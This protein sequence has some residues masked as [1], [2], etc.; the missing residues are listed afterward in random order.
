MNATSYNEKKGTISIGPGTL[1][2]PAYTA[3]REKNVVFTAG[4]V[5]PVGASGFITGGGISYFWGSH[6]WGW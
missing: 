4:R 2:G 6:G 5:T 1:S 3:L